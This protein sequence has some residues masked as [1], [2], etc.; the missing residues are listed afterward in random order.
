VNVLDSI[1]ITYWS[2]VAELIK[3]QGDAELVRCIGGLNDMK[4]GTYTVGGMFYG[5]PTRVRALIGSA[6][7]AYEAG[8]FD[9]CETA[10]MA[11]EAVMRA[12]PTFRTSL[13]PPP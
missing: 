7:E 1:L 9:R 6:I 13:G 3:E 4:M 2:L 5:S 10:C 12:E 11:A 8:E